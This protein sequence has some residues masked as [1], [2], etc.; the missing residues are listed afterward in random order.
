MK[1]AVI[2]SNN[3]YNTYSVSPSF[4]QR[5]EV[6]EREKLHAQN[7]AFELGRETEKYLCDMD[8][9]YFEIMGVLAKKTRDGVNK[10]VKESG[11]FNTS[12]GLTFKKVNSQNDNLSFDVMSD[13]ATSRYSKILLKDFNNRIK[14]GFLIKDN[15]FIVKNYDI[16]APNKLPMNPEFY[17]QDEAEKS[18]LNSEIES[19][20]EIIDTSMCQ[21]RRFVDR[22]KDSDL[23]PVDAFIDTKLLNKISEIAALSAEADDVCSQIPQTNLTRYKTEFSDY[24]MQHGRSEYKFRNVGEDNLKIVFSEFKN[25]YKGSFTRLM[26][27]NPDDTIKTGYLFKDKKIVSNFN[28][29]YQSTL[30]DKLDFVDV[31]EIDDFHYNEELNAYIDAYSEKLRTFKNFLIK[32]KDTQLNSLEDDDARRME[33]ITGLYKDVEKALTLVSNVSANKIKNSY[34]D[35]DITAGKKGFTFKNVGPDKKTVNIFRSKSNGPDEI[36]NLTILN[37]SHENIVTLSIKNNKT[38][39]GNY[40]I[41]EKV[42]NEKLRI[43]NYLPS[44][45]T[46]L[47][48]FKNCAFDYMEKPKEP[49]PIKLKETKVKIP[50]NKTKPKKKPKA[51]RKPGPK[52]NTWIKDKEYK[53]LINSSMKEFKLVLKKMKGD[54]AFFDEESAKIRAKLAAFID[55]KK[56]ISEEC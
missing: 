17:T 42:M 35:Y 23:K 31:K 25:I 8:R 55:E 49:K 1:T 56:R 41:S 51:E 19:L 39:I 47:T 30:P 10:I 36:V 32:R 28:P 43:L 14:K 21:T 3:F 33:V 6:I 4:K 15:K 45:K 26:V 2:F 52:Q 7:R 20:M 13:C 44:L 18:G 22:R 53:E 48:E 5:S 50:L 37:P 11:Q 29:Q 24:V 34:P 40:K 27:Y 16:K 54:M 12:D 38:Y 46:K 9:V